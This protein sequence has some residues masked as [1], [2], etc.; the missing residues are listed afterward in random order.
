VIAAAVLM[1]PAACGSDDS[2]ADTPADTPAT[3]DADTTTT[4]VTTTAQSPD[5]SIPVLELDVQ[6]REGTVAAGGTV[7]VTIGEVNSSVGDSWRLSNVAPEGAVTLVDE[8]YAGGSCGTPA[9][10]CSEGVLTWVL[11]VTREPGTVTFDAD[12]CYRGA[13]PGDADPEDG[14]ERRSYALTVEP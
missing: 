6:T 3:T 13:C 2:E 11:A 1:G 9:P 10:G 4:A 7:E 14:T 5:D 12:N 8:R